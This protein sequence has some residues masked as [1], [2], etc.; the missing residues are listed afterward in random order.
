[1]KQNK[2]FENNMVHEDM[3][4]HKAPKEK[5]SLKLIADFNDKGYAEGWFF[6]VSKAFKNELDIKYTQRMEPVLDE[7]G[8]QIYEEFRDKKGNVKLK[9]DGKP[10]MR[11]KT[12]PF[13]RW[14]QGHC[15]CFA[16]GHVLYDSPKAY[17]VWGEALKHFKLGLQIIRAIPSTLRVPSFIMV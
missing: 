5:R 16:E 12:K 14:T 4:T 1:M 3:E 15:Y 6:T 9:K 2:L 8:K 7:N 10:R 11:K 17:M 13:M